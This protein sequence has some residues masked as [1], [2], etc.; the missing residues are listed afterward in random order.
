MADVQQLLESTFGHRTLRPGQEAIIR[1]A[2]ERRDVLA[3]MPT[4]A[5]KSLTYQLPALLADGLTLVVSPLIALMSDQVAALQARGVRAEMLSSA[6]DERAQQRVLNGLAQLRLLYVAPERLANPEVRTRLQGVR[7]VRLVVDEAHCVS[8]WGH[9]FRPDYRSLSRIR[10]SLGAP[11]VTALTATATPAVRE[12]IARVLELRDPS[13]IVTGFDRPNLRYLVWRASC[14]AAKPALLDAFLARQRGAGIVYVGT[15][16]EAETLVEHLQQSGKRA[17]YYHAGRPAAERSQVQAAFMR[18][19]LELI[20]ATNA[21][22]MGVDKANVRF[23]IHMR[24]PASLE[25]YY[26]EA[27]RAGRDGRPASCL[28][29][30]TPE[31]VTLQRYLIERSSPSALDLKRLYLY[32]R[33]VPAEGTLTVATLTRRL[34]LEAGKL[35]SALRELARQGVVHYRGG[36]AS[37]RVALAAPYDRTTPRFEASELEAHK[38]QRLKL[39]EQM[40]AFA[41]TPRCRRTQLLAYFADASLPSPC[42]CDVCDPE[43][44]APLSRDDLAVLVSLSEAPKTV[45]EL[46]TQLLTG[47]LVGYSPDDTELHLAHLEKRGLLE[48]RGMRLSLSASGREA[49]LRSRRNAPDGLVDACLQRFLAGE[50][51]E[52][53]AQALGVSPAKVTR[54]LLELWREGKVPPGRLL[55]PGVRAKVEKAVAEHGASRL[56][57]LKAA[58]PDVSELEIRAVLESGDRT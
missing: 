6:Q 17:S 9:D 35:K 52:A 16:R 43:A 29:L 50:T 45:S 22:G 19:R 15:R 44:R 4:G 41:D 32:L 47:P 39:L 42:R 33:N 38:A 14:E 36:D 55:R 31:D 28:L 54:T 23:V 3:V 5:G 27:G 10:Q 46:S 11:P 56:A 7:L 25:A 8:Q 53:I 24:L 12:D 49:L 30:Y 34:D 18:G 48:R 20:V 26:Q 58:L 2:L 51:P 57:R 37:E 13:V 40:L 21:F 1:A